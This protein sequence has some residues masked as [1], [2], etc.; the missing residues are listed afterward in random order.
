MKCPH[1]DSPRVM[2][3]GWNCN[4]RKYKC[5]DCKRQFSETAITNAPSPTGTPPPTFYAC[6]QCGKPITGGYRKVGNGKQH[7][8]CNKQNG[9]SF[10]LFQSALTGALIR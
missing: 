5:R 2:R 3:N 10:K 7:F 1:C 6:V 4:T 9:R 8:D